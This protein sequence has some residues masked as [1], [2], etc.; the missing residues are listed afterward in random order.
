MMFPTRLGPLF[1][2]NGDPWETVVCWK[3]NK[4]RHDQMSVI[5]YE[6]VEFHESMRRGKSN[7]RQTKFYK[8]GQEPA[9]GDNTVKVRFDSNR[10][11]YIIPSKDN[12]DI[13]E[14]LKDNKV[15]GEVAYKKI[16]EIEN[17]LNLV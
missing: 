5:S 15:S 9:C 4:G 17:R 3:A 14:T 7:K 12:S 1:C 13:K 11:P 10:N 2:V 16:T 6:Y 8:N